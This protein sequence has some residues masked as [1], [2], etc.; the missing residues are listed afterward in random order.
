MIIIGN[1]L[2]SDEIY[3]EHFACDLDKCKGAC[4]VE[5]DAGAPLL[6]EEKNILA[7]VF[8]KVKPYM[9]EKGIETVEN[10][11]AW[12]NDMQG[13]P[14][15]PLIDGGA[16][17]YVYF[18][19][20][21]TAKCAIETAFNNGEIDFPKPVSCHL[22]PVRVTS[23]EHYDALNYHRWTICFCARKNEA[24]SKVRVFRFVKDAIVR[25]YGEQWYEELDEY[26]KIAIEPAGGKQK[27]Q[28]IDSEM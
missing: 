17:A 14:V 4:C 23:H 27:K 28:N 22:Y 25:K 15:T 21:G 20:K 16:C 24:K 5:G 19:P 7:T 9:M 12:V 13:E 2:M 6:Q 26:V 10:E 3:L 18:D 1:I 8:E 11:G